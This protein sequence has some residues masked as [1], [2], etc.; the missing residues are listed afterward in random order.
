MF[1][2]IVLP[3]TNYFYNRAMKRSKGI[4][5]E[6]NIKEKMNTPNET[7]E[8]AFRELRLAWFNSKLKS[9]PHER[10]W[11][12]ESKE[13][14]RNKW[15]DELWQQ[16]NQQTEDIINGLDRPISPRCGYDIE[17]YGYDIENY[18]VE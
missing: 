5:E 16:Y 17:N 1:K 9:Y 15:N 12:S 7:I 8:N 2:K 3:S 14:L 6:M 11:E 13:E 4:K 10:D 18:N